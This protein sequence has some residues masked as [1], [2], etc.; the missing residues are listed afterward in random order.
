MN[1]VI[2]TSQLL[3]YGVGIVSASINIA[4]FVRRHSR[5]R[6]RRNVR[7]VTPCEA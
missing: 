6:R 2:L 4:I 5:L 1:T 3:S 7:A